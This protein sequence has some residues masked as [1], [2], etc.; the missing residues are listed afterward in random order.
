MSEKDKKLINFLF[1]YFTMYKDPLCRT[2]CKRFKL[3]VLQV[4]YEL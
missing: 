4:R 2:H 3:E 1:M